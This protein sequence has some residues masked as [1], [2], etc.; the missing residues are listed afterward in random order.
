MS[1]GYNDDQQEREPEYTYRKLDS[2]G[3]PEGPYGS[4]G[5]RAEREKPVF[6]NPRNRR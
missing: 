6:R 1:R 4:S 3:F 2:E 5:F